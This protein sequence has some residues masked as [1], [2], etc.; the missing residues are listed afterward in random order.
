MLALL[1]LLL[2]DPV[3]ERAELV[4]GGAFRPRHWAPLEVRVRAASEIQGELAI[5]TDVGFTIVQPVRVGP[6][7]PDPIVTVLAL[8][9]DARLEVVLRKD[10]REL[11]R[12][13]RRSL[14][15]GLYQSDRLIAGPGTSDDKTVY[16]PPRAMKLQW[17]E[18]VDA[19]V[20]EAPAGYV[21]MGGIV[22]ATT[23]EALEKI[24]AR[25][26]FESRWFDPVD[27]GLRELEPASG[28]IETRRTYTLWY[29]LLYMIAGM[30]ALAAAFRWAPKWSW[31]AAVGLASAATLVLFLS[32]PRG[33][34]SV[35]RRTCD[36]DDARLSIYFVQRSQPGPVDLTFPH[37]V[38]P[39]YPDYMQS[40]I[41]AFELRIEGETSR[42][43][44]TMSDRR[45]FT[46]V[47][48]RPRPEAS[49]SLAKAEADD[50]VV[51]YFDKRLRRSA[52]GYRGMKS[53]G[54]VRGPDLIEA[55]ELPTLVVSPDRD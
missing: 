22:A 29:A 23:E 36:V 19:V 38:K 16:F 39:A 5:R 18:A 13:Q 1:A 31:A 15:K 26:K 45:L 24:A 21:A 44:G 2:Q 41:D 8:G 54:D 49:G 28:W 35:T 50:P 53:A 43:V 48:G 46:A 6:G 33:S 32:F 47:E 20:G 37:L 40:T 42:I 10:G 3:V 14:G 4:T 9:I 51:R 55:R 30:L 12:L 52:A 34:V 11:A 25:G 7:L 17:L 27:P